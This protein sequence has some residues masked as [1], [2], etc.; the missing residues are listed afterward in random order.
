L[1]LSFETALESVFGITYSSDLDILGAAVGPYLLLLNTLMV[2]SIFWTLK[3]NNAR[4]TLGVLIT[5][6]RLK[7]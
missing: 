4:T 5:S 6:V 7:F 2:L 1:L 3:R